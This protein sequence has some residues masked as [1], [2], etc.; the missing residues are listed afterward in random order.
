MK[1]FQNYRIK[2]MDLKNRLVM[3][4]MCMYSS[5]KAGKAN[6]FH[7]THYESR[8]IGGVG[9]IIVEATGVTPNGR[10]S[11]ND[12]GI[13]DDS[14]I[15]GL[16]SIVSCVKK[17]GAS[18]A[19]QLNHAGR[20]YSGTSGA[21]VAPSAVR[22]DEDS[23]IP[24]EL[25]KDQIDGLILSYRNAALRAD[26]AGFDAIEIHAAHGYLIHQFFSPLSNQRTDEYGGNWENRTRFL[27]EILQAIRQVWPK[28]KPVFLRVSASDYK[29]NGIT[30][31]N[32][33][34]IVNEVREYIDI[35]H[36]SSGGL[37]HADITLYPGYQINYAS[38]IKAGCN[39][40]T[41]AVGLITDM[42]M[43]EEIL[44]NN[45]ADLVAFGRELLRNPYFVLHEARKRNIPVEYP[46]QYKRS[47][48]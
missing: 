47:F 22:F 4:P 28:E 14:Q 27:K 29:E 38:T 35:V 7:Y 18:I 48:Q 16:H 12:L 23:N 33:V 1:A 36:V 5:D 11:D 42:N 21:L 46:E 20:K 30:I 31:E 17:H 13:W 19:V 41:I 43:A 24:E 9:L 15:E 26:M 37:V 44:S 45:R 34:Q 32:M 40:P 39:I 3:P 8:A 25:S 2:N 6:A 10:I